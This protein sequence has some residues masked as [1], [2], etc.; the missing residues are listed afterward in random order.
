MLE[1]CS[2]F[3]T[4]WLHAAVIAN[5]RYEFPHFFPG[6][7]ADG[8]KLVVMIWFVPRLAIQDWSVGTS[9]QTDLNRVLAACLI[10]SRET[11]YYPSEKCC[12][13]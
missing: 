9:T 1:Q 12:Q 8:S 10:W 13:S 6:Y 4:C 5:R 11:G 3:V 7:S 2:S